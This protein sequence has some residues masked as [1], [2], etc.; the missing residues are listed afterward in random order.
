MQ[1]FKCLIIIS[2]ISFFWMQSTWSAPIDLR[3]RFL[4]ENEDDSVKEAITNL[5]R[6]NGLPIESDPIKFV[7][8]AHKPAD[9]KE[10]SELNTL[11]RQR[12]NMQFGV[13]AHDMVDGEIRKH[14]ASITSVRGGTD[15]GKPVG[16]YF[17]H[18]SI[19]YSS[20]YKN[21]NPDLIAL[22]A[23]ELHKF[24]ALNGAW[25]EKHELGCRFIHYSDKIKFGDNFWKKH[26]SKLDSLSVEARDRFLQESLID[27]LLV[28]WF[29]ETSQRQLVPREESSWLDV[30]VEFIEGK[31]Q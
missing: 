5:R 18:K 26:Y 12:V 7:L 23:H 4:A 13:A 17:A 14:D 27:G 29:Y 28:Y 1:L 24:L 20:E 3:A 31:H 15:S 9:D 22:W 2:T 10:I 25:Y 19:A 11:L 21:L 16:C 8:P 30:Q 6:I